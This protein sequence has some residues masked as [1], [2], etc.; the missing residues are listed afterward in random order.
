[1]PPVSQPFKKG[2][3]VILM[4]YND[5]APPHVHVKYQNDVQN[6]RIEIKTRLWMTPNKK[7]PPA[8]S[9]MVEAWVAAHE[10][11]LLEQWERARQ[12]EPILIVG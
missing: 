5:H 6:Y 1:M 3:L 11:E 9:H 7:L 4:N 12:H 2:A 10:Q 8:L